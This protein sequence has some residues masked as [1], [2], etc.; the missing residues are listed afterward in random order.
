MPYAFNIARKERVR[1]GDELL[2]VLWGPAGGIDRV[3]WPC[4][5]VA[6]AAAGLS[7]D[8]TFALSVDAWNRKKT[9]SAETLDSL[10]YSSALYNLKRERGRASIAYDIALDT[11]TIPTAKEEEKRETPGNRYFTFCAAVVYI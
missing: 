4:A 5:A 1:N 9:T 11:T 7:L 8:P 10:L 3:H 2:A 6:A